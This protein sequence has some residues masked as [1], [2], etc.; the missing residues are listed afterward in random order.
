MRNL[1]NTYG[2]ILG[3]LALALF[4]LPVGARGQVALE[5]SQPVLDRFG[6]PPLVPEGPLS[7]ELDRAVRAFFLD[8]LDLS[9]WDIERQAAL[10]VIAN[11]G[12]PRLVWHIVDLLRVSYRSDI[13]KAMGQ[14]ASQLLETQWPSLNQWGHISDRM[15]AW[16]VP[17]PPDYLEI[18]RARFTNLFEEW[19]PLFV[20]GTIDWRF[21]TWGG[22][23]MDTRSFGQTD[24]FC[25]CIPAA[26]NPAVTPAE[27]AGWL[28]DDDVVFG[29]VVNGEARA[30][31]RQIM[32]VREM[33]NDTLGGR[34]LGIP[35]CTLCGS[36]QAYFTDQVPEDTARPILRT[37]GLLIR[38]N[39]VMFDLN[40]LSIFDTFRGNAVT[41]S[42]A[43]RGLILPQAPMIT[44][45]WGRWK[46]AYP[47]TTV[48][49]E[50]LA[51]GQ[52]FDF[53]STR[54]ANGPIFPVGD[55]D[56]RLPVQEDVVGVIA[57]SGQAIAFP[58]IPTFLALQAGE[59]IRYEDVE[60]IEDAG[61]LRA[62]DLSGQA[63]GSHQAF[64]FAWSQ[65][66]PE[67]KLWSAP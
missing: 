64:W 16:N 14:A 43:E 65:F 63:L 13:N 33:V 67:T 19:E 57:P 7:P 27:Q 29:L 37:S 9:D 2:Y 44:T 60:L 20:E 53:R 41:G 45:R 30:Y 52:D 21:V 1:A 10:E 25:N 50:H 22:V 28:A 58:R 35:Y 26:D 23:E 34:Q 54:D 12:D 18:K 61:G 40:S 51:L 62:I 47:E 3:A 42:L 55:I 66:H 39:K 6:P 24:D 56:P 17:A 38:S 32:E 11:S 49:A 4:I 36:A 46:A 5:V 31:P 59:R 8:K 15:I 48:L